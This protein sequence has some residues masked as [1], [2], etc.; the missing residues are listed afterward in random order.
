MV[1]LPVAAANLRT[2]HL[3]MLTDDCSIVP[4]VDP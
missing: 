1:L 3:T 2:Q 4:N